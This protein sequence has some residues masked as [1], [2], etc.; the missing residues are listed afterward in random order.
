MLNTVNFEIIN[1][2]KIT[3]YQHENNA[4]Y[5][6]TANIDNITTKLNYIHLKQS[7]GHRMPFQANNFITFEDTNYYGLQNS[8]LVTELYS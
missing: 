8:N 4:L 1:D 6:L 2:L 5:P 3:D 7:M